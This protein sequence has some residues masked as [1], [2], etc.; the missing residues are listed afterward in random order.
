MAIQD[1]PTFHKTQNHQRNDLPLALL[2]ADILIF[3]LDS[4]LV[5]SELAQAR[6]ITTLAK[7]L[8]KDSGLGYTT[9]RRGMRTLFQRYGVFDLGAV[10][11]Q[12][13]FYQPKNKYSR[14][15]IC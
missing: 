10:I 7:E 15:L 12:H 4:T 1:N 8:V 3:D 14:H 2:D 6:R 13:R 11:D 9:I 5:N